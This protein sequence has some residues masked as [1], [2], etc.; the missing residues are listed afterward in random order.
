N[1]QRGGGRAFE[2]DVGEH[3]R[4]E[5]A[6]GVRDLDARLRGAR[7]RLDGGG[8]ERDASPPF[9]ALLAGE[10]D[11]GGRADADGAEVLLVDLGQDPHTGE[12]RDLVQTIGGGDLHPL[13][14][15]LRHHHSRDRGP[16]RDRAAYRARALEG[17]NLVGADVE[18][19]EP[20]AG[21]FGQLGATS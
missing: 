12:V 17:G 4:L 3:V 7:V 1:R 21:G 9:A 16:Q 2:G 19:A 18:G 13:D 10:G 6:A 14:R 8:D 5:H 11:A 15:G 20:L